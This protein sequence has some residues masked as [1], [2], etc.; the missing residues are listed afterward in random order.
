MTRHVPIAL[1]LAALA[2]GYL[3][4]QEAVT[5][6]VEV[7]APAAEEGAP[8]EAPA[9]AVLR[10]IDLAE[11]GFAAG[12][13]FEQLSGSAVAF[14]PVGAEEAIRGMTLTLR[15]RHGEAMPVERHLKLR[16]N[17]RV[18]HVERLD[19]GREALE[20]SLPVPPEA[21]Q[22]G[23]VKLGLEYA[24]ASSDNICI[25]ERASGDFLTVL[26]ESALALQLDRAA[27][28]T[29]DRV[30][31][32]MPP[33][34]VLEAGADSDPARALPF[35]LRAAALFDAE[36][37]LL[38][39]GQGG[40]PAGETW[41][42]V[43]L[44]LN[45]RPD[46]AETGTVSLGA[47]PAPSLEFGG[48]EPGLGLALA[49]SRWRA[50]GGGTIAAQAVSP[51]I[52]GDDD[53][54]SFATL[55][56][57]ELRQDVVGSSTFEFSVPADAFAPGRLPSEV[58]LLIGA[59]RSVNGRGVTVSAYLNN[60]L[61]GSRPLD[62]DV[63]VWMDFPIPEGLVGRDNLMTVVVQRQTEGGNCLFAPQ[64][65]PVQI[66]PQSR[67]VTAEAPA[68]ESDFFLMRQAFGQ[69]ADVILGEGETLQGFL[70][71]LLPVAGAL[72]PD[73][74]EVRLASSL[75][76]SLPEEGA[77][78]TATPRP[79]LYIGAEAPEGSD[80]GLRFDRGRVE[81][82]D[83]AG[84]VIFAGAA[85]DEVGLVQIVEAEGRPGVWLRPGR[86]P[87]P[88]PSQ[89]QPLLLDRGDLAFLDGEGLA[90]AASTARNDLVEVRYPD[91]MD[92]WQVA[93]KYRPWIVGAL[94]LALTLVIIRVLSGIYRRSRGTQEG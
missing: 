71:W 82:R 20:V 87:A 52:G 54:V 72:L 29:V 61:L 67:F 14:F 81:L 59:A 31:Q 26:P 18:V 9:G 44:G 46:T 51:D 89:A 80:P 88:S 36:Y 8:A 13:E 60:T 22:G 77:E 64:G 50:L 74:A 10:E 25:D 37:G 92:L 65:Y 78:E 28:D 17:D 15:L 83:S 63:P 84:E 70:P 94:W 6:A 32:V 16:I 86:G 12:F 34:K 42:A 38:Q 27:L 48:A 47:G 39:A 4:A 55:G 43:T 2:P 69:G 35:A 93:A 45:G 7:R 1:A 30:A 3:W 23:F 58:E 56:A 57:P 66:L 90:L 62:S 68:P 5:P 79:F 33:L 76:A 19:A 41:E 24:G 73:S 75:E 40:L 53:R 11:I 91:R 21:A 49:T 85:L